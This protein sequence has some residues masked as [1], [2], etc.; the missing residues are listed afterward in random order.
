MEKVAGIV[1]AKDS[2]DCIVHMDNVLARLREFLE[3][4]QNRG[5]S[6]LITVEE[7]KDITG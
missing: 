3:S 4:Q 6:F 2:R 5:K 1:Y 7:I